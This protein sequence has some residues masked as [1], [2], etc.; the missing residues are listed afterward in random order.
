ME[1]EMRRDFE[2]SLE[3]ALYF[4]EILLMVLWAEWN[5]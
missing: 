4:L 3:E 1:M 5:N 2:M